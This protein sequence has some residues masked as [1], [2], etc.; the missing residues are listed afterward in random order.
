MLPPTPVH[1]CTRQTCLSICQ[2]VTEGGA[3]LLTFTSAEV[4]LST[5]APPPFELDGNGMKGGNFAVA[6][7]Q[8]KMEAAAA[9]DEDDDGDAKHTPCT[10]VKLCAC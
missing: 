6:A 2:R 5:V 10:G 4:N 7:F 3:L 9:V 8:W 1:S